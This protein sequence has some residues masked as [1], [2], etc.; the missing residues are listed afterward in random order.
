MYLSLRDLERLQEERGDRRKTARTLFFQAKNSIV[1]LS[2]PENHDRFRRQY[3]VLISD[4]HYYGGAGWIQQ[5]F[6]ERREEKKTMGGLR[7]QT[8]KYIQQR[9]TLP[10]SCYFLSYSR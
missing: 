9:K 10:K 7:E 3:R 1:S 2:N 4:Y 8:I 6:P 5:I